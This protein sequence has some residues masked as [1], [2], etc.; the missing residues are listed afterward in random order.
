MTPGD[1]GAEVTASGSA[2]SS[3]AACAACLQSWGVDPSVAGVLAVLAGV[4]VRLGVD[5]LRGW[6]ASRASKGE[7][8]G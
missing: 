7:S 6:L 1:V 4:A 3:A 2:G 5:A 8:D